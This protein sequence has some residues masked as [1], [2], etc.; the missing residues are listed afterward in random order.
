MS[1]EVQL[2]LVNIWREFAGL[3]LLEGAVTSKE[4]TEALEQVREVL[5]AEPTVVRFG[6]V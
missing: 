4:M 6:A 5:T 2:M 3:P 1:Y